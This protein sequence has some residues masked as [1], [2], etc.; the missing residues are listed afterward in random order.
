[1]HLPESLSGTLPARARDITSS[2]R[3]VTQ[4]SPPLRARPL[5]RGPGSVDYT[6]YTVPVQGTPYIQCKYLSVVQ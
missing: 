4:P 6:I 2:A 3:R 5:M 1:M